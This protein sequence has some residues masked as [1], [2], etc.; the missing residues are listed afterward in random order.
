MCFWGPQDTAKGQLEATATAPSIHSQPAP[1]PLRN[2]PH[3]QVGVV[4]T[5]TLPRG[6]EQLSEDRQVGP[7]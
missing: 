7:V 3:L 2:S 5:G 6:N 4:Q 1:L